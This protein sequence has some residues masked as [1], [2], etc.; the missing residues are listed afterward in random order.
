MNYTVEERVLSVI[1]CN[2]R[3]LTGVVTPDKTLDE[4]GIDSFDGIN[5]LYAL[6]EE[7]H[8]TMP[9]EA[10]NYTSVR[11]IIDG[12]QL[13]TGGQELIASGV[14]LVTENMDLLNNT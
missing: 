8:V 9:D 1:S 2:Q 7:F 10:R 3:V 4:L 13:L 12:M 11:D 6:E 5:L 14:R